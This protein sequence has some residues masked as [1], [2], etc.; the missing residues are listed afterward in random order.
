MEMCST[1]EPH[2]E[3]KFWSKIG[4]YYRLQKNSKYLQ[5]QEA[6]EILILL[7]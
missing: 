6:N 3:V 4:Y 2:W 5:K 7:W 1:S